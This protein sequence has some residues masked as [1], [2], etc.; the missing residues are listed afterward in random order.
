V[1]LPGRRPPGAP[2]RATRVTA[3]PMATDELCRGPSRIGGGLLSDRR[4]SD[5]VAP[6]PQQLRAGIL[7]YAAGDALSVPWE[8][9]APD[10]VR[11]EALEA[12]PARGDWPQARRPMTPNSC[13]WSRSISSTQTGRS[14]SETFLVGW[15]GH[16]PGCGAPARPPR[17]R[18][19]AF[20]RRADS[21]PPMAAASARPCARCHSAGQPR[22]PR[23]RIAESS[24]SGSHGQRT[25]LPR[26]SSA[27]VWSPRWPPGPSSSIRSM[28]WSPPGFG[29]LTT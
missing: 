14:M 9:M 10:E 23:Q 13:C 5:G 19:G 16:C 7:A 12:L 26:R 27:R 22:S 3:D 11:W 6:T 2:R 24:P 17:P 4:S 1:D 15:P 8:G 18:C 20:R 21:T 28:P 29:K 25:A